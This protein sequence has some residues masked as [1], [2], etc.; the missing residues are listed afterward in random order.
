MPQ[1]ETQK[2]ET[3]A[4]KEF[5]ILQTN[6]VIHN[7]F[8]NSMNSLK[9]QLHVITET[10]TDHQYNTSVQKHDDKKKFQCLHQ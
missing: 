8:I 7:S 1:H 9:M 5:F 2:L 3:F 4:Q 10:N 6:K